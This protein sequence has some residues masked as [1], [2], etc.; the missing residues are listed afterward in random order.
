[1]LAAAKN[2][3]LPD[4]PKNESDIITQVDSVGQES[5]VVKMQESIKVPPFEAR[6]NTAG[7][8]KFF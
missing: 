2:M 6:N 3:K 4:D 5:G 8:T 7:P 1:M